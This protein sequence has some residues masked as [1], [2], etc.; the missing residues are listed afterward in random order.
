MKKDSGLFDVTM[1]AYDGAEVCELVGTFLLYK[2]SLKY[3]K[4][5]IG[6]Y[7]DDGLAIFKNISGPKSE[8]IKKN[9][10]KLFKENQL[11]I[12]IQCNMKTV[13]YLDVTLNL[14]NSTY[15]PYK[16]ENNQIKYINIESNHPPSIIKQLP[17]SI[18]S[19]LSSLS[20]SEETN[21]H[22]LKYKPNIDTVTNK[23]Q[24]K[25]NI[26]WFN[27]PYSKNVKT[28]IR[29]IFLNLIKKHFPPHHKFH[30]LFNKNT[31][32]ISY[33]C[34]RNI[35]SI[36]NSHNAKILF[37]K[38]STEQRTCNCLNKVNCP[39][40]Q[41]CLTTNI[42][43][44]A[45]ITSSNQNYQEKV[46]FGSCETTFK[47]RFSNHRKSFNLKQYKN[48]RELSNEIWRIKN[49]GHH[50]KVKWEIVKKCVPYSP[51]TKRCLLCLNEKLEIAAYK[52]QNSPSN[53]DF[54]HYPPQKKSSK[55][56]LSHTKMP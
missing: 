19:R 51:Q 50:P 43:Y 7:R 30:K 41:K 21:K 38:K 11:E 22:K 9:I 56:L 35:K 34:T 17:L 24:R 32:K 55:T 53:L 2:L 48:E 54:H 13:N 6:L 52:E 40:E 29:K 3:N 28:N 1:G 14:E 47:K 31:V 10:Q 16:K 46:Y 49:S 26:I 8:K 12:V 37:P 36:I 20:S 27:P 15:R 44:K 23:K 33:C 39:L 45:N 4:N 42:V 18:E 5:Q 25:R